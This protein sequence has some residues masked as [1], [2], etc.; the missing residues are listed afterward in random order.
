M[1]LIFLWSACFFALVLWFEAKAY[2]DIA[3]DQ[4]EP[5]KTELCAASLKY[6]ATIVSEGG[7]SVSTFRLFKSYPP[8]GSESESDDSDKKASYKLTKSLRLS[9]HCLQ[10]EMY[11]FEIHDEGKMRKGNNSDLKPIAVQLLSENYYVVF[12]RDGYFSGDGAGQELVASLAVY[13]AKG[14]LIRKM[15]RI[16]SWRSYEGS[17]ALL[18][19]C[20]V[21]DGILLRELNIDPDI[22]SRAGDVISYMS[23]LLLLDQTLFSVVGG[24]SLQGGGER[25]KCIWGNYLS[26]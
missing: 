6:N 22:Q 26:L 1:N 16:S 7:F 19:A 14:S 23:P 5:E 20:V 9:A 4:D 3:P 24:Y 2:A 12:V 18:D 8:L 17:L 21:E 11:E 15:D 10:S 13:N 25:V